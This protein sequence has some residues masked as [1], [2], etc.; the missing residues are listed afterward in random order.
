VSNNHNVLPQSQPGDGAWEG[1]GNLENQG[2]SYSHT[3]E[4]GGIYAYFCRPHE[5]LGMKGAIAV[6]DE[7]PRAAPGGDGG[8]ITIP[9]GDIGFVAFAIA[10]GSLGLGALAVFASEFLGS[11]RR[12]PTELEKYGPTDDGEVQEVAPELE[13]ATED[14]EHDEYDPKGTL[15]LIFVYFVILVGMWIFVYFVEFLGN[16]PSIMG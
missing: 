1:Y 12:T 14:L 7:V 3:F 16:G 6:G 2:F 13:G 15:S 9:G 11:I 4:T 10:F 8:G 5:G